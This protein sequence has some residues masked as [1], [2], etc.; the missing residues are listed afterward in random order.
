MDD[1]VNIPRP[2]AEKRSSSRPSPRGTQENHPTISHLLSRDGEGRPCPDTPR[3]HENSQARSSLL[4][5]NSFPFYLRQLRPLSGTVH[6]TRRKLCLPIGTALFPGQKA[7][8]CTEASRGTPTSEIQTVW[9]PGLRVRG[10][11]LPSRT[12]LTWECMMGGCGWLS[13]ATCLL[14]VPMEVTGVMYTNPS[15]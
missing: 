3:F 2:L 13:E 10:V 12:V 11:G 6:P 7:H 15:S 1:A 4:A 9:S 14:Q 8:C 5:F